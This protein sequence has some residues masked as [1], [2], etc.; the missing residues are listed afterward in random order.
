MTKTI[1]LDESKITKKDDG[2]YI[3][4][5]RR[6]RLGQKY[7]SRNIDNPW[8]PPKSDGSL[9]KISHG[10][11]L[12]LE[13]LQ[14]LVETFTNPGDTILDPMSG[15]GT[16][17]W[18]ATPGLARNTLAI[19]IEQTFAYL[20]RANIESLRV[21]P[22][23]VGDV[24]LLEGDCR[25]FLP[26]PVDAVIFSPPYGSQFNTSKGGH[27]GE[28]GSFREEKHLAVGYGE[29]AGNI[30]N[31]SIYPDYLQAMQVVYKLCNQSLPINGRMILITGDYTKDGRRVYVTADNIRIAM[32]VGFQI[33]AWH[34]RVKDATSLP[35]LTARRSRQKKGVENKELDIDYE[36][37]VVLRKIRDV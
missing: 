32:E 19:E 10:A 27:L 16:I 36:D 33:E 11:S 15:S 6:D 1:D 25:M 2:T 17:H 35:Q 21:A 28:E 31:L 20:Q 26:T 23:L 30:G 12:N 18:A 34:L 8:L 24:N 4:D 37:L 5:F 13:T 9:Q 7:F 3:L 22:G 29:L 14:W